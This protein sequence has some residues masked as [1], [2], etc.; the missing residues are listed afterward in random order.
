MSIL[1]FT[2]FLHSSIGN[3]DLMS[4]CEL[5]LVNNK[6]FYACQSILLP[7][8]LTLVQYGQTIRKPAT[9]P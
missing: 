3:H 6:S 9:I 2:S 4:Q 1:Q 8:Y 7:V 5:H